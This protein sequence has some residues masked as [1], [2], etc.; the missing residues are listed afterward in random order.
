MV[1]AASLASQAIQARAKSSTSV[2]GDESSMFTEE[3][4]Q[5]VAG[6]VVGVCMRLEEL[7]GLLVERVKGV[8]WVKK[9][10]EESMFGLCNVELKNEDEEGYITPND[11]S[12]IV[13]NEEEEGGSTSIASSSRSCSVQQVLERIKEDPLLRL[14]RAECM[15]ALF[16]KTVEIPSMIQAGQVPVDCI[17]KIGDGDDYDVYMKGNGMVGDFLDQERMDVLFPSPS[18]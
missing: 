13:G 4:S 11:I 2:Q 17:D 9:Y 18:K 5:L 10:G 7:E 16:L 8:S 6:R 15:Y 1:E 14:C 12:S 3:E